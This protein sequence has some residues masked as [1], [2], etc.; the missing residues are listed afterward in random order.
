MEHPS[1]NFGTRS[2][3]KKEKI[4]IYNPDSALKVVRTSF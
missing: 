4:K 2:K 1:R 3:Y